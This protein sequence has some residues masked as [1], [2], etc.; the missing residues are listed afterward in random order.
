LEV[1]NR[2]LRWIDATVPYVRKVRNKASLLV[3]EVDVVVILGERGH[4]EINGI[5]ACAAGEH[6]VLESADEVN[7]LPRRRKV[8]LVVPTTQSQSSSTRWAFDPQNKTGNCY[9]IS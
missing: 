7:N 9:C 3:R 1:K 5:V 2:G 4:P 6:I 8:G